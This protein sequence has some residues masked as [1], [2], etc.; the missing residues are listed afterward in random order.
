[1]SVVL[2][3]F[4][5]GQEI[6]NR[7]KR[8]P[9]DEE[10]D[11]SDRRIPTKRRDD[12]VRDASDEDENDDDDDDDTSKSSCE[13]VLSCQEHQNGNDAKQLDNRVKRRKTAKFKKHPDAPKRFRRCV[14][15]GGDWF[16]L[17][18]YIRYD[19]VIASQHV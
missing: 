12:A 2:P 5:V 15:Y 19:T 1:M 8:N 11:P 17:W 4:L 14:Q 3:V 10:E 6:Q 13:Q 7:R 18:Q 16:G 9:P